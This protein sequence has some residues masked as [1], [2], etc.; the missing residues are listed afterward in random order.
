LSPSS[1][2]KFGPAAIDI[3]SWLKEIGLAEHTELFRAEKIDASVLP[4]LSDADLRELGLPLGDRKKLRA[5]IDVLGKASSIADT[6][7]KPLYTTHHRTAAEQRHLTVIFS[8]IV[9]STQLAGMVDL[10]TL[11]RVVDAYQHQVASCVARYDG[12]VAKFMG[13]GVLVYFGYPQ[14]HEDDAERAIRAALD[15]VAAMASLRAIDS[16]ELACRIGIASGVVLVG[17]SISV[18]AAA[19]Q[20]VLGETPNLAARLQAA[21][22]RNGVIVVES[23][24]KLVG[25][26]FDLKPIEPLA[27][28]G[29]GSAVAAWQVIAVHDD[30]SRFRATRDPT[31]AS[32]IGREAELSLLLNRWA[33][34]VTGDGQSFLLSGEAGLGKSRLCETMLSQIAAQPH[35]QILLQCS[36]YHANSALYPVL[37]HLE[38]IVGLVHGDPPSLRRAHLVRL[39]HD[40]SRAE[41]FIRLLG[42]A[43][44][45]LDTTPSD[46]P[47]AS[48]AETLVMLRDLLL[49]PAEEQP[50]CILVEDA[51]WIDPTTQEL[52]GLL[53]D[54]LGDRRVLLLITHRPEFSPPW[55]MSGHLTRLAMNRLSTRACAG[56]I[57]DLAGGKALPEEV[58]RQ[59]VAKAEGIPLFVEEVTKAVLE[60]G[61]LR[62]D[63]DA[64]R[65]EG[66][67]PPLAIPSSLHDSFIARL[68]RMSPV[69]EIAQ[70][71]AAIGREFSVRLL[72][73]ALGMA[74][75]ALSAAL[76]QLV[77]S[78][79][80]VN[81]GTDGTYAFNH[82]LTRD[83]AYAS[84]LKSRRQFCHQRI[85]VALEEFDDGFVRATQPEL[86]A[87]HF[88]EA[89]NFSAALAYWI[90]A[91]DIA[92][93]RG[94][95][96]EAVA[97]FRSAMKLTDGV[98]LSAADCARKPEVLIKLS[99]AQ[100]QTLG[101]HSKQVFHLYQE[102]RDAALALDQQDEAATA[103]IQTSMFLFGSCRLNNILQIG[104]KILQG[105]PER[106]RPETLVHLWIMMASASYHIGDFQKSVPFAEKAIALDDQVNCTHKA[107][108]GGAD[109]AIV[110]RD[111]LEMA[112]R[113]LGHLDRSLS[114]SEQCMAIALNRG[115]PFS[116][117]WASVPRIVALANFGLYAEAV[118]CAD[119]A[120]GICAKHGFD[121]RIGNVLLHRGPALFELGD[122]EQGLADLERG[123]K[124][125]R[126]RSGIF[127][128]AR[129]LAKLAEYQ[130]RANQHEQADANLR[131]AEVLAETSEEKDHL[132]ELLRLRG[133]I[134][135][136]EGRHEQARLCF[137]LAIARSREQGARLL[138]LNAVAISLSSAVKWLRLARRS[139]SC[140]PSWTGSR[141]P[142]TFLF[143]PNAARSCERPSEPFPEDQE[144]SI[145]G[146]VEL[147]LELHLSSAVVTV[148]GVTTGSPRPRAGAIASLPHQSAASPG[149]QFRS[150]ARRQIF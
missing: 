43:L 57:G 24:R 50:L 84:L 51:H 1:P 134:L 29:I 101:Y 97:H 27:L 125:W 122:K 55:R 32:F 78:G 18:G 71:G 132:S 44:G 137:E 144:R 149:A 22:P 52:L 28:K 142:S 75:T 42:P 88:Q 93:R 111:V 15:I 143:S 148:S 16:F 54:R 130:L 53:I 103:D 126:E 8:D 5:A 99:N 67:L 105:Q 146:S 13:D 112:L 110:A 61:L 109:P 73:S 40:T 141:P 62:E 69:K 117:V 133:R 114:T 113:P 79:L 60:S 36:P 3:A 49:A 107:P 31:T 124:Q 100:M 147:A 45:L 131:E 6:V 91:G 95:N 21:A 14:A 81:G 80:L 108:W 37:R 129:N 46:A 135:Q 74:A 119:H 33:M 127:M 115:H 26:L 65:F 106:M 70:M 128:L 85:A 59:I 138:E 35:A 123:V 30:T 11:Q 34:A 120:I 94:A 68:D 98:E 102:A 118:A 83:A 145:Q 87:Y 64:W 48:K 12:F 23:T 39:F 25:N 66:P 7:P 10:E 96:E 58:L 38:R 139:N 90:A 89:G 82:A 56:L 92:E 9:D 116:I 63:T 72:A 17:D 140:A 77:S 104:T 4:T 20:T 121:S 2:D 47:D 150:R 19:E 76:T 86:L 136:T 41:E